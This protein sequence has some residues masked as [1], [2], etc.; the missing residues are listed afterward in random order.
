MEQIKEY[1]KRVAMW[2][3]LIK[4]SGLGAALYRRYSV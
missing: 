4:L 1:K 3:N 2:I